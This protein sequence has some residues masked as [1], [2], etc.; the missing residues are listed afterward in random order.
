MWPSS[1]ARKLSPSSRRAVLLLGALF[2][3]TE[4]LAAP[5]PARLGL[6]LFEGSH[7]LDA[8]W[9]YR[10]GDG[11]WARKSLD[12]SEWS[13]IDGSDKLP[14]T[15]SVVWFRR[16]LEIDPEVLGRSV[17]AFMEVRGSVRVYLDG[18]LVR[19]IGEHAPAAAEAPPDS[20]GRFF[21]LE[22]PSRSVFVMAGRYDPNNGM[23][24]MDPFSGFRLALGG[25]AS[26]MSKVARVSRVVG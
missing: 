9:L 11:E 10:V 22:L 19:R 23:D 24:W 17:P 25:Q 15:Q 16:H 12:E 3:A 14:R 18:V 26:I 5:S 1:Q 8:G 13:L 7:V 21:A 2:V 6:D 4:V 20:G